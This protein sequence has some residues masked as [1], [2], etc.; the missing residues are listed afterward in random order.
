MVSASGSCSLGIVQ[1]TLNVKRSIG[2]LWGVDRIFSGLA[3]RAGP[4]RHT[5]S[6][7]RYEYQT[8]SRPQFVVEW[9]THKLQR[10]IG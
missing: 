2:F 3:R 1:F 5:T 10:V 8:F 4:G 6:T 9:L 7:L